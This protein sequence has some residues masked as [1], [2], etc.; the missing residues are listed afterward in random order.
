MSVSMEG[1]FQGRSPLAWWIRSELPPLKGPSFVSQVNQDASKVRG[2]LASSA[3]CLAPR[4]SLAHWD[5]QLC[6]AEGNPPPRTD[7]QKGFSSS[8]VA[9]KAGLLVCFRFP[10]K[11]KNDPVL[12]MEPTSGS[13]SPGCNHLTHTADAE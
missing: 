2:W 12:K 13:G 3:R 6:T 1:V 5:G 4:H 9:V 8:K 11:M 10:S 7:F